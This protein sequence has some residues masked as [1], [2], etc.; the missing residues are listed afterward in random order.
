MTFQYTD[1]NLTDAAPNICGL[2]HDNN[3]TSAGTS[4]NGNVPCSTDAY[5]SKE[6]YHF[7]SAANS[8]VSDGTLT[9]RDFLDIC[10][11]DEHRTQIEIIRAQ[12][13]KGKRDALKKWLPAVTI[14]AG[15]CGQRSK[16]LCTDNNSVICLD[17]DGIADMEAAKQAIGAVPYIF[18][19]CASA[20]GRGLFALAA[21][22]EPAKDLG[23]VL[24]SMQRDF[25]YPIDTSC[26]DISRLRFVSYDPDLILKSSVIPFRPLNDISQDADLSMPVVKQDCLQEM[27]EPIEPIDF[28]RLPD[29]KKKA[30]V[31][32]VCIEQ[33]LNLALGRLCTRNERV[34]CYTG[35]HWKQIEDAVF[36]TFLAAAA[37]KLGVPRIDAKHYKFGEELFKQ[38]LCAAHLPAPEETAETKIN[39]KNGTFVVSKGGGTLRSCNPEDFLTYQLPFEYNPEATAPMFLAHLA[40]VLPERELQDILAE[41]IGYVFAPH[42][43]LEKASLLYGTG[44]NG[45]SVIADIVL[46]LLGKENVSGYSLHSI[47]R[48]GSWERAEM[49]NKLLNYSTENN[50]KLEPDMFKKLVSG[51][52]VEAHRKYKDPYMMTRYARLMFNCN[53][54]PRDVELTDGFFRRLL[55]IPFNV[56][57]PE[58][59]Q[60]KDLAQQIIEKEL[61]GVFNW[62]L[63]GL[64]RLL[65]NKRFTHSPIVEDLVRSYR[66]ESDSAAMFLQEEMIRPSTSKL[67]L[68]NLYR[69]YVEFCKENGY[70]AASNRTFAGRLRGFGFKD[71]KTEE[72]KVFFC[73][74]G[75]GQ[76]IDRAELTQPETDVK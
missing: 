16:E 11:S 57:I 69:D 61:S 36:M 53:V 26:S 71:G 22:T 37:I 60:I 46:A 24:S 67:L 43:K 29:K 41:S 7:P 75:Y 28:N 59:D 50:T 12:P 66:I 40:K 45:K 42:L 18:A 13:D 52:P 48:V 56:T 47:T 27:L 20:S 63:T 76:V 3:D 32:V 6:V 73:N 39:L 64:Y 21:L 68:K 15:V 5:L 58:A 4:S 62:V 2:A 70:H 30:Q 72:G 8:G 31:T 74:R 10:R 38:F 14:Q 17:F 51:E 23:L 44:A 65:E 25:G 33:V 9:I 49:E 34:Y 54:L 55:I 1:C 35:S 19:V